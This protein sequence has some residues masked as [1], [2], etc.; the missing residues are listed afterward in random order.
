LA[1]AQVVFT[2]TEHLRSE[3]VVK[4]GRAVTVEFQVRGQ[5]KDIRTGDGQTTGEVTVDDFAAFDPKK[6]PDE[7]TSTSVSLGPAPQP[8]TST[9]GD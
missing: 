6:Q 9:T 5:K 4:E 3:K 8:S 1:V 7:S 2:V